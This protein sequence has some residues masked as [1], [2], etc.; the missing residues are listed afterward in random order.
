MKWPDLAYPAQVSDVAGTA[1]GVCP[2]LLCY[3]HNTSSVCWRADNALLL[4]PS[5]AVTSSLVSFTVL[6]EK[7]CHYAAYLNY[8]HFLDVISTALTALVAM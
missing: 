6:S 8:V 5:A 4:L 2:N 3:L 7:H 1:N